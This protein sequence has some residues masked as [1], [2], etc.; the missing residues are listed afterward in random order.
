[1]WSTTFAIVTPPGS[2]KPQALAELSNAEA[3]EYLRSYLAEGQG[4]VVHLQ[5]EARRA[6]VEAEF[7]LET[8]EDVIDLVWGLT[9]FLPKEPDEVQRA[10]PALFKG[11]EKQLDP[12][13]AHGV[14][15]LSY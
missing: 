6:G 5:R 11:T 1:M 12:A 9:S 10:F 2:N 4:N 8:L 3:Q 13:S 14:L 7:G 15:T